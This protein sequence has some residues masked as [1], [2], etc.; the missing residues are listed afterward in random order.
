MTD[1]YC[2][3]SWNYFNRVSGVPK[4]VLTT[5][6]YLEKVCFVNHLLNTLNPDTQQ[7]AYH[8]WTTVLRS[9]QR[10]TKDTL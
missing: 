3:Y 8:F 5:E 10:S 9:L 1:V 4:K 7:W 2:D 6:G